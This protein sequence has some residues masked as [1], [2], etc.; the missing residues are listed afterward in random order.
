MGFDDLGEFSLSRVAFSVVLNA[1]WFAFVFY[2]L[3]C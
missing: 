2:L 1:L 3:Q